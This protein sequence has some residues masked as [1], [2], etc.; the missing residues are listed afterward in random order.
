M[1]ESYDH[2]PQN[3]TE[4]LDMRG[5][6]LYEGTG[7]HG[8]SRLIE[9]NL[10][11]GETLNRVALDP[12][13]FGEGI[14]VLEDELFQLTYQ[15]QLGFVYERDTLAL[16]RTFSYATE[17]WGLTDDGL[18]LIMG[19]GSNRLYFLDP[20]TAKTSRSLE[21]WDNEGPVTNLNEL[22]YI[23]G[24][25]YANIWKKDVIAIISP[26]DGEV[27][28]WIDLTGLKPDDVEQADQQ[29]LNGIAF[30]ARSGRLLVTGK[31]WPSLYAIEL[32]PL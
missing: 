18:E 32:V 27:R 2:D 8:H 20:G 15:S 1:V 10:D 28:G 3:F 16:E 22:E 26:H 17:G 21:V 31:C 5:G 29:V 9:M 14:T 25:I 6:T 11:T 30:D 12:A 24:Q 19:D 7:R 23:D 13:C 4:G